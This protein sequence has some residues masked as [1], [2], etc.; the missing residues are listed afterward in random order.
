MLKYFENVK[1][2]KSESEFNEFVPRLI[3][4]NFKRN[5]PYLSC[6]SNLSHGSNS[7][8][9]ASEITILEKIIQKKNFQT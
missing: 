9:L 7:L 5:Q 8:N 1:R 6:V 3:E 2:R 4:Y